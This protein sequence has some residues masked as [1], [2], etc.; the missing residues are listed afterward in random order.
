[1]VQLRRI[2][3]IDTHKKWIRQSVIDGF[4]NKEYKGKTYTLKISNPRIEQR[5]Y[6]IGEQKKALL[7]NRNLSEPV[8]G[9]ITLYKDGKVVETKKNFLIANMPYHT[10][11][12]SI[13]SNGTSYSVPANQLRLRPG[14]YTRKKTNGELET[15]FNLISG[16]GS[17]FRIN[18]D[19]KK[20]IFGLS[21]GQTNAPLYPLLKEMGVPDKDMEATWGKATFDANKNEK[22]NIAKFYPK[23]VPFGKPGIPDED[24]RKAIVDVFLKA[25]M[26]PQ[27]NMRTLGKPIDKLTPEAMLLS[28][29]KILKVAK[30]EAEEDDR[31]SLLYKKVYSAEDFYKEKIEKDAGSLGKKLMARIERRG[32]IEGVVPGYFT[33]QLWGVIKGDASVSP[34]GTLSQPTEEI[35]PI[36]LYDQHH[37]IT[38]MGEGGI[39]NIREVTLEARNVHPSDFGFIDNIRTPESFNIGI[40]KRIAY[41]TKKGTD[42]LLYKEFINVKTG[43]REALNPMQTADTIIAFADDWKNG[44][45][46]V[47][48]MSHGKLTEVPRKDVKYVIGSNFEQYS[49]YDNL[50]PLSQSVQG[51]RMILAGKAIALTMPL[52]YGEAPYLQ[53][54]NPTT[55]LSY[56]KEI[57]DIV[58]NKPSKVDG[59]VQRVTKDDIYVKSGSKVVRHGIYNN[60]P[61]NLKTSMDSKVIVKPGD[62]VK[63]GQLLAH[64]NFSSKDG[65]LALGVNLRSAYFPYKGWNFED[66]IV[67]SESAAK[68]LTSEQM[69]AEEYNIDDPAGQIT[70]KS[71]FTSLFPKLYT[72]DTLSKYDDDGTIKVGS[73]INTGEPVILAM[74]K[75][76]PSSRDIQLGNLH[77]SL[78]NSFRDASIEWKHTTT[79]IV[80]DVA[81][82]SKGIKVMVKT[83][84]PAQVGD[85]LTGRFGNKGVVSLVLPD[86]EM[87]KFEADGEPVDI[88]LNPVGIPSRINPGQ[89]HEAVLQKIAKKT[90]KPYVME[91]FTSTDLVNDVKEE[92]KKYGVSTNE[93]IIVDGKK[94]KDVFSGVSYIWKLA[95]MSEGEMKRRELGGYDVDQQP[96]KGKGAQAQALRIGQMEVNA[97]IGHGAKHN[98]REISTI[99]GQ[100]N[101]DFWRAVKLGH[102]LPTPQVPFV[103]NKFLNM[104]KGS[105]INV[106]KEGTIQRLV[107]LTN[108]EVLQWSSGEIKEPELLYSKNFMPVKGGLFDPGVTG[109]LVGQ[110]W[111]H[112]SLPE[113][114]P[115]P[116]MEDS[117]K[118]ILRVTGKAFMT[119]VQSGDIA[120]EL[121]GLSTD[122]EIKKSTELLKTVK[123]AEKDTELK[124]LRYLRAI[125]ESGLQPS[126]LLLKN[127][128]V[129]PPVFRPI[130]I[131]GTKETVQPG[132][133]NLLYKDLI[134]AKNSLADNKKILDNVNS[135]RDVAYKAIKA[136]MGIDQ[137]VNIQNQQKGVTGFIETVVGDQP[138]T[139]FF[140]KKVL[141][142]TQDLVT[143]GVVSPDPGL[144]MDTISIPKDSAW[145]VFEPFVMRKMVQSG[146]SAIAAKKEIDSRS[147]RATRYL[148]LEMANRPAILNRNPSLHK[149]N[150]MAFNTIMNNGHTIKVPPQI[151]SGFNMDFDGDQA[152]MY[153][154]V[155]P[156][157]VQEAKDI[158]LPSKNLLFIKDRKVFQLPKQGT[159]LGLYALT[160]PAENANVVK[161]YKNV[162]ELK[163][164]YDAGNVKATDLVEVEDS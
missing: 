66:G 163:K 77:K 85:K 115:N 54:K 72:V 17:G 130:S 36:D 148:E 113:E 110:N 37:K 50:V 44:K 127:I 26:D 84:A 1:M 146:V 43:K 53:S 158:L 9:D 128:P 79:G 34:V 141:S 139:G 67:L 58:V 132:N 49:T 29:G 160:Q 119:K 145:Q 144:D 91:S 159:V 152:N 64:S 92:A 69:Y 95:K 40:D 5:D 136:V 93:N 19:P 23:L 75:R 46:P 114:F 25:R 8:K 86:D 16:T 100:R 126:D 125:K 56:E 155:T 88:V 24:K 11:R 87:P 4:T 103:Y 108:K 62:K 147:D 71:K 157:A 104:L 131:V 105:G 61:L 33:K 120:K 161:K 102:T 3:D 59:V 22:V 94:L 2:D 129:L 150:L 30:N 10:G 70:N 140:Q 7:Y 21:L 80:T 63:K 35:N 68:K 78:R 98:L 164:D 149:F 83:E 99:K 122:E 116:V 57:A 60:F 13:V 118:K 55:G 112:I 111:A 45:D 138:K 32:T 143:R 121:K 96:I 82:T 89:M 90:G 52:K 14:A 133:A 47:P 48:V 151:I 134:V 65:T 28:T 137:P 73:T 106:K 154:P 6:S 153:V 109:G 74:E 117:L 42:N 124:R 20:G 31:D 12:N 41:G 51:N 162:E 101:D 76:P 123:G 18:I 107:P 97:L 38:L 27:V 39:G 142:K 156:E 135:E 15:H 81:K